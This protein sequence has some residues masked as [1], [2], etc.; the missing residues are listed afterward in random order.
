M[1]AAA[2]DPVYRD[3]AYAQSCDATIVAV[4]DLGGI[5]LDRTVFYPT[6]GGQPGDSGVLKLASGDTI[7][8]ATTVKGR[9]EAPASR[10]KSTGPGVTG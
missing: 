1:S 8:I 3:D 5:V 2:T 10:R 7:E 4:N 6:G 9:D